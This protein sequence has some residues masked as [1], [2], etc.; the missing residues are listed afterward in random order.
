MLLV[1]GDDSW[2]RSE[3]GGRGAGKIKT[4]CLIDKMSDL[5]EMLNLAVKSTSSNPA[6]SS[7]RIDATRLIFLLSDLLPTK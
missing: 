3:S 7:H 6:E 4:R 2:S 1:C 5:S